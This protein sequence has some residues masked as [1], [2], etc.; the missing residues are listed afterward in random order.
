MTTTVKP[1]LIV[2]ILASTATAQ[3]PGQRMYLYD[4]S[5]APVGAARADDDFPTQEI[6]E[7]IDLCRAQDGDGISKMVMAGKIQPIPTGTF[8][9]VIKLV[10]DPGGAG[11]IAWINIPGMVPGKYWVRRQ[12]L[13]VPRTPKRRRK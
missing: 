13:A 7:Y 9:I 12:D 3:M 2:T 8:V 4:R 11:S 1:I 10:E 5:G 6:R